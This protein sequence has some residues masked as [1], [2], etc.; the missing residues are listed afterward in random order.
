MPE[1]VLDD[2]LLDA[3]SSDGA[4]VSFALPISEEVDE[5]INRF[6]V[7]R[8][9]ILAPLL[10][11]GSEYLLYESYLSEFLEKCKE[12]TDE[13]NAELTGIIARWESIKDEFQGKLYEKLRIAIAKRLSDSDEI[14]D[15][16]NKA[17]E[18]Y[19]SKF[20][21]AE[22]IASKCS[23]VY[24][25][26]R[27]FKTPP[28]P[29]LSAEA[30]GVW[31]ESE[32][33]NVISLYRLISNEYDRVTLDF[34]VG[35]LQDV[36]DSDIA[37]S[38]E[39]EELRKLLTEGTDEELEKLVNSSGKRNYNIT[40]YRNL[41]RDVINLHTNIKHS[42]PMFSSVLSE[43]DMQ[44]VSGWQESLKVCIDALAEK[45]GNK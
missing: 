8:R 9:E 34:V 10:N 31:E 11:N 14:D 36:I 18:H 43:N 37:I 7:R 1:D 4:R 25:T 38:I 12:T 22:T 16:A 13:Y 41:Q 30:K 32:K 45:I 2:S 20:P 40:S 3:W 26:P 17:V 5:F 39:S 6:T 15:V 44:F 35:F 42:L 28:P 24:E 23:V 21:S 29:T 19:M 33:E 27:L